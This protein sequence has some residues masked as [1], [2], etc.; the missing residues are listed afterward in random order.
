MLPIHM[1]RIIE[2]E[3]EVRKLQKEVARMKQELKYLV[4]SVSELMQ[5]H[6]RG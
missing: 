3:A 2:L 6:K 4:E 1:E 5:D